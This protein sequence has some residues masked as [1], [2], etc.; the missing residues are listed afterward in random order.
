VAGFRTLNV[1]PVDGGPG[2][3]R[4]LYQLSRLDSPGSWTGGPLLTGNL[5]P[6]ASGY[7]GLVDINIAPG[8]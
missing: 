8:A 2:G 3:D 1:L 5:A 4:D 7:W 6:P